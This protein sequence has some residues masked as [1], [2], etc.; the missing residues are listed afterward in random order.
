MNASIFKP[1]A[2]L[3]SAV[4]CLALVGCLVPEKFTA[5]A[6]FKPDGSFRYQFDGTVVNALDLAG[7]LHQRP[8]QHPVSV[9]LK[10]GQWHHHAA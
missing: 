10:A 6:S 7:G 5:S 4:A 9:A 3:A 2:L 1:A 8:A